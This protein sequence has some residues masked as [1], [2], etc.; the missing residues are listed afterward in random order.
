MYFKKLQTEY[1]RE[2]DGGEREGG[3]EGGRENGR[4][5]ER[6][7]VR[8]KLCGAIQ[9]R[10]LRFFLGGARHLMNRQKISLYSR[11]VTSYTILGRPGEA[12]HS[13]VTN[14][15]KFLFKQIK[16]FKIGVK[17]PSKSPRYLF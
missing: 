2:G 6:Q 12:L 9:W 16:I 14:G 8:R 15:K 10:K 13:L 17:Y 11:S 4:E 1:E 3:R 7:T 5:R